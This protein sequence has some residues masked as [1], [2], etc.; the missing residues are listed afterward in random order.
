MYRIFFGLAYSSIITESDL[1]SRGVFIWVVA[2]Y[3]L[4]EKLLKYDEFLT[5]IIFERKLVI[6]DEPKGLC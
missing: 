4:S 3:K 1:N 2:C 5:D 6:A